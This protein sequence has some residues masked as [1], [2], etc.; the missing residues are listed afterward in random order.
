MLESARTRNYDHSQIP[1]DKIGGRKYEE[2]SVLEVSLWSRWR[3]Y[4]TKMA[5]VWLGVHAICLSEALE[6][7]RPILLP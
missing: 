3:F 4:S 2:R 7:V 1:C 6:I 5:G